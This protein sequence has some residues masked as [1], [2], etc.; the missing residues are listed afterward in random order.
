MSDRSVMFA[1]ARR[2]MPP[3]RRV[4]AGGAPCVYLTRFEGRMRRF[5][6]ILLALVMTTLPLGALVHSPDLSVTSLTATPA[7][8]QAGQTVVFSATL[9][10][11]ANATNYPV[12]FTLKSGGANIAQSLFSLSFSA[13]IPVTKTFPWTVP[14]NAAGTYTMEFAVFN[15]AW[16]AR[17]AL[18]TTALIVSAASGSAAVPPVNTQLPVISGT[19][20]VGKVL[21]ASTG[22]WSGATSFKHN[23]ASNGT[24]IAGATAATYTAS[25]SDVGKKLT[26]TVTATGAGGTAA[27]TTAPTAP[28]VA[29]SG[30]ASE[31]RS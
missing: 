31:L 12:L 13:G 17:L 6:V 9:T 23:W 15:P 7:T 22:S 26:D 25:A 8:V 24:A 20:Q 29:E 5:L 19:A 1:G 27:A 18:T 2:T 4:T 21:T 10:A 16:S 11:N 30:T 28:I 14:A 3:R